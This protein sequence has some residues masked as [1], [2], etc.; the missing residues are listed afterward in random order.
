MHKGREEGW[1]EERLSGI[2][3]A[4][5]VKFGSEGLQLMSTISEISDLAMLRTIYKYILTANTFDQLRG[6]IQNIYAA[7]IH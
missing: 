5:D 4:L 6:R 1:V 3:L 7:E 2:E